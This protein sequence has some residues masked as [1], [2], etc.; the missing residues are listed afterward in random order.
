MNS[1]P[2]LS[3]SDRISGDATNFDDG[4][5]RECL[6]MGHQK[7]AVAPKPV[8][9][10]RKSPQPLLDVDTILK[11]I[12]DMLDREEE[13]LNRNMEEVGRDHHIDVPVSDKK[14][15]DCFPTVTV[16]EE[17][18]ASPYPDY[19][20]IADEEKPL[21]ENVAYVKAMESPVQMDSDSDKVCKCYFYHVAYR[22]QIL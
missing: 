14:F 5:D 2:R 4:S 21:Y 18:V 10:P 19:D 13:S 3:S 15:S 17:H 20:S 7:P 9:K 11:N 1:N 16:K 8:P 6:K 22:W 12:D